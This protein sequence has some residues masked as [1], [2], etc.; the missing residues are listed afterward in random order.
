M[1]AITPEGSSSR[2]K[3][4]QKLSRLIV[5]ASPSSGGMVRNDW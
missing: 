1:S 5:A 3:R 2:V 4:R